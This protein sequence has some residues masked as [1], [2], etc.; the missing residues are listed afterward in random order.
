MGVVNLPSGQPTLRLTG[1]AAARLA[2]IT[3]PGCEA[4]IHLTM[5]DEPPLAQAF[6]VIEA[7]PAPG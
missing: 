7:R 3:P 2:A 1:G 5:T 4:L 6:V